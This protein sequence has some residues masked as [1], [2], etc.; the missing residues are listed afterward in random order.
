MQGPMS[1]GPWFHFI[2]E[3]CGDIEI[4]TLDDTI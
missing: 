1:A 3:A 4:T 2:I